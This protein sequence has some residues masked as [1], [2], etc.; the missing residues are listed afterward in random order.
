M[1]M[2]TENI[3]GTRRRR[4]D[5]IYASKKIF[6]QQQ[7]QPIVKASVMYMIMA[8]PTP[9]C[10][11]LTSSDAATRSKWD[12]SLKEYNDKRRLYNEQYGTNYNQQQQPIK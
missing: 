4:R 8:E 1:E 10:K 9:T 12:V 11:I 6:D 5:K 2:T 3:F 7:P